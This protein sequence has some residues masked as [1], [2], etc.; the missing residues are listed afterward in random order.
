MSMYEISDEQGNRF[1]VESKKL[2]CQIVNEK[3]NPFINIV[4]LD[5]RIQVSKRHIVKSYEHFLEHFY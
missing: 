1:F 3:E 2:A 4:E 5:D